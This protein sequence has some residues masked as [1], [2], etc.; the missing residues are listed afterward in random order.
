[1]AHLA[2]RVVLHETCIAHPCD[3][4]LH[5]LRIGDQAVES[6]AIDRHHFDAVFAGRADGG[7][8]HATAQQPDLAEIL[9]GAECSDGDILPAGVVQQNL[10]LAFS[11]DIELVGHLALRDDWGAAREYARLEPP[12]HP[13]DLTDPDSGD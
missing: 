1:S 7:G 2:R 4:R 6:L 11:D 9:A 12:C 10:D 13:A 5:A 3:R 8:A